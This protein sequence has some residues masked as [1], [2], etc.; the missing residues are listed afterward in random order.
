MGFPD[1]SDF[2]K[3]TIEKIIFLSSDIKCILKFQQICEFI[4][5]SPYN[6]AII[7]YS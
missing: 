1:G 3:F 4:A 5:V 2:V 7:S 6:T